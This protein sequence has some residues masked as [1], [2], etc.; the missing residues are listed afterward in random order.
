MADF[1]SWYIAVTLLGW[2][3]FPLAFRLFPTLTDRGYSLARTFGL[4]LWGF[5]YWLLA[6]LGIAQNDAGGLTLALFVLAGCSLW[7]CLARDR[8]GG[9]PRAALLD[10][11]RSNRRL[12]IVVELLFL[13][14]FAFLALVRAGNPEIVGTEKPMELAFINAILRSPSFP[15]ADPWLSGYSISYYYFGYVLAAMLARLTG[16][17]GSVAFNLMVALVFALSAVGAY[18]IVHTL[19]AAFRPARGPAPAPGRPSLR[20]PLLAPIFLLLLG[21]FEAL[22]EA[23]HRNGLFWDFSS[24]PAG[25]SFWSWLD[26]KELSDQPTR[27]GGWLPDRYW[28]WWRASRV[29]QDTDLSGGVHEIIDEFPAFSYLL[30]DLHPHVLAMPFALLAVGVALNLFLGGWQT[31]RGLFGLRITP[32]GFL[33]SALVVGGMAFLNTW[34]ILF[35]FALLLGAYLLHRTRNAGP[36]WERVVET[37]E[38]AFPLGLAAI[39]LYLPFHAGFSSQF[40]GILANIVWPTRGAHLWVMFGALFI[41]LFAFLAQRSF[42]KGDRP[43]WLAGFGL[44][45][46][47]GLALWGI[48]WLLAWTVSRV[49]PNASALF[50]ELQGVPGFRELFFAASQRRL[51]SIGGSLTLILLLGLALSLLIP[52]FQWRRGSQPSRILE[53]APASPPDDPARASLAF[54]L[55]L[56]AFGSLLALGPDFVYL[57]DQ[58]GTR[59][60]TVFKFYYEAWLLWSL[61]AAFGTAVLLQGLRRFP[62]VLVRIVLGVTMLSG[63]LYPLFGFLDKTRNFD[64]LRARD[65][66]RSC[67]AIPGQDC[68]EEALRAWEDWTL[69]GA[70]HLDRENPDDAAAIRYLLAAPYGVVAEATLPASYNY[71]GR[72]STHSG[73]PTVLGWPGHESQWRGSYEPQGTRMEDMRSLYEAPDWETTRLILEKYHIRYVVVGNLERATYTV[74]ETKFNSFLREV[75]RSG[76]LVIYQVP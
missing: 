35:V 50:L 11:L 64:L 33:V 26:I 6:S 30:G 4:L 25:S 2:L 24:A 39:L 51:E 66:Y 31:D 60:N 74:N 69:D 75:F 23:L 67:R 44:A 63:L 43:N 40:G 73:L 29:V 10:W 53:G 16:A 32:P 56:V 47:C 46:G 55:L 71:N 48:S 41:P 58:F 61:A 27:V 18:G 22:L 62:A 76:G 5:G 12:V 8:D 9:S 7:A 72:I 20:L 70:A 19:L 45:L 54:V 68:L 49:D 38:F 36:G 17:A 14:A 3:A 57:R 21:N 15:P 13:A 34:D 42:Q 65:L 52:L 59:L 1:I 28:W 37:V